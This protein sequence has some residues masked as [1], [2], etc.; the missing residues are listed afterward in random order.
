MADRIRCAEVQV[1]LRSH[2]EVFSVQH[3]DLEVPRTGLLGM[4]STCRSAGGL[5]VLLP[6]G[7][8]RADFVPAAELLSSSSPALYPLHPSVSGTSTCCSTTRS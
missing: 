6:T 2:R 4:T 8:G 7:V 1:T 5:S 3:G